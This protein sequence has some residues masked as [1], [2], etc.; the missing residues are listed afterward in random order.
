MDL[1]KDL[2]STPLGYR[3]L[4]NGKMYEDAGDSLKNAKERKDL[5]EEA[6]D[7]YKEALKKED[8]IHFEVYLS[9]GRVSA[10]LEDFDTAIQNYNQA[11]EQDPGNPMVLS[12]LGDV[13]SQI[14]NGFLKDD[15]GKKDENYQVAIQEEGIQIYQ[16]AI[17]NY[18]QAREQ[19]PGNAEVLFQ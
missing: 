14:G 7:Y 8:R 12:S 3:E 10:K 5:H 13:Y 15:N 17:Q 9:L 2:T 16:V 1:F 4:Q 6:R 19:D 18:N 11:I